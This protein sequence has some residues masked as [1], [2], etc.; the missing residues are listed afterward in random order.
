MSEFERTEKNIKLLTAISQLLPMGS[1]VGFSD[2]CE[3]LQDALR[4]K[5]CKICGK[6]LEIRP[7]DQERLRIIWEAIDTLE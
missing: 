1:G 3:K 2:C 5:H 4:R 7:V 6:A